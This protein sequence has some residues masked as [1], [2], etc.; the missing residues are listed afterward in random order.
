MLPNGMVASPSRSPG[1]APEQVTSQQAV[2]DPAVMG[3][4]LGLLGFAFVFTAGGVVLGRLVGPSALPV[5]MVGGFAALI[6]L[7]VLKE[8]PP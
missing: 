7:L 4:V 5:G 6:A 1:W 2:A 3:R 8:N